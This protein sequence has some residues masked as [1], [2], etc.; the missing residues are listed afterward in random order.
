MNDEEKEL[1]NNIERALNLSEVKGDLVTII[2]NYIVKATIN[3]IN[4]LQK[5]L[6]SQKQGNKDLVKEGVKLSAK[7]VEL[8]KKIDKKDKL[9]NLI[10]ED[11]AEIGEPKVSEEAIINYYLKM[12]EEENETN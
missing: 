8:E 9:I 7:I 10:V 3:L 12:V 1:I 5:E 6:E 2:Y 11:R 4:K